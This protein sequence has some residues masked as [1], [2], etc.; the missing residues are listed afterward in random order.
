EEDVAFLNSAWAKPDVNLVVIV[1]WGGVGKSTLVN[2]W[3]R[4]MATEHYRSAELVF[5]WSFYRQGTHGGT[6][7]ADEFI[8]AALTWVGDPDLRIGT[9]WEKGE[10][11]ANLVA[12]RRSLVVLDGLE[13]LQNRPGSQEGR[14][15][16]ASL[17]AFLKELAAFNMGL[18]VITTRL[19]VADLADHERSSVLRRELEHLSSDAGAKLLRAL[20]VTG[21]DAELRS[22]SNEFNGHCLALTLLGSYLGDAYNGRIQ[23][24]KEVSGHLG[25]DVRQGIHA[26]RVMQSYQHWFGEGSE[27]AVLRMLAL[28]AL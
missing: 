17:E 15:R 1:A 6:A 24:R 22:A 26:R 12:R 19:P 23:C 25:D 20:G 18:C 28:F 16:E 2:H 3:L 7:S 21:R 8:D 9:A 14:L 5:G 27:L 4:A 13:P 11:L 10:R